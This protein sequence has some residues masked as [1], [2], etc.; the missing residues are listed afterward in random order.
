MRRW[1]GARLV[2]ATVLTVSMGCRSLL[3]IDEGVP[4][5]PADSEV[6]HETSR[7]DSD[8]LPDAQ[9]SDSR[10]RNSDGLVDSRDD[11]HAADTHMAPETA[12]PCLFDDEA[13]LFDDNCVFA[14]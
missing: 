11:G 7:A 1:L 4:S 8:V 9:G 12:P 10:D 3:G 2:L 13:S 6:E 14:P 5:D